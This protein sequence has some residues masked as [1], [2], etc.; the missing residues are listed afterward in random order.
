MLSGGKIA[1]VAIVSAIVVSSSILVYATLQ[2]QENENRESSALPVVPLG[3]PIT[4]GEHIPATPQMNA[5]DWWIV[6]IGEVSEEHHISSYQ[7]VLMYDGEV[8]VGPETLQRG[9]L[10]RKGRIIFLFY[11]GD[12]DCRLGPCDGK[13]SHGDYLEL[14]I[15]QPGET[16]KVRILWG[17]TG[18]ILS[19]VE[20]NT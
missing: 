19:E 11:E 5:T 14:A 8:L 16:Y 9:E 3:E 18:E 13:L 10:G 7:A 6:K 15:I 2:T 17:A 20:V 1:L 4:A 12:G